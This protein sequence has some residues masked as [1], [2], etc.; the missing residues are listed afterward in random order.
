MLTSLD[1]FYLEHASE[2]FQLARATPDR[3]TSFLSYG[4]ETTENVLEQQ[5]QPLTKSEQIARIEVTR[6]RLN[7]RCKGLLEIVSDKPRLPRAEI[8]VDSALYSKYS[9][10]P[11]LN[12]TVQYLHRTVK[13][14][15]ESEDVWQWLV[16]A[17]KEK[18][19]PD[20]ALCKSFVMQ[21][22]TTP[23][24]TLRTAGVWTTAK[25]CVRHARQSS[26]ITHDNPKKEQQLVA[27]LDELNRAAEG[28]MAKIQG[29]CD[30]SK[31]HTPLASVS[32]WWTATLD[33][34]AMVTRAGETFLSLMIRADIRS[35]V[36]AKAEDGYLVK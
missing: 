23:H 14:F 33:T 30:P 28:Q 13:D 8:A 20:L 7:S 36:R 24:E 22:K 6:R 25:A 2:L 1:P 31:P 16:T 19:D 11:L 15:I 12:S 35:Y 18:Y 10:Y 27:L 5:L 34:G 21:F 29:K 17:T 3:R 26:T 9:Q 4:D 32:P